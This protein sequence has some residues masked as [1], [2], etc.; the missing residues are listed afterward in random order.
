MQ[1]VYSWQCPK[2]G[3][4]YVN[5]KEPT[6]CE[7]S[8]FL[9][10]PGH[11]LADES[12]LVETRCGAPILPLEA[13]EAAREESPD[14]SDSIDACDP[15]EERISEEERAPDGPI[16]ATVVS[17]I[18]ACKWNF[19]RYAEFPAVEFSLACKRTTVRVVVTAREPE[20]QVIVSSYLALKVPPER[21][22]AAAEFIARVNYRCFTG[23]FDLD[24]ENGSVR[25]RCGIDV[26]GGTLTEKMVDTLFGMTS[27]M[28]DIY[29]DR[30]MQVIYGGEEPKAALERPEK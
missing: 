5:G 8:F 28:A 22:P 16:M 3:K 20:Q 27:Y 21:R 6:Y 17:T 10:T 15:N 11:P 19:A 25:F 13:P 9:K 29:H 14:M 1:T 30:L 24:F 12:G 4:K 2:C 26:E 23:A 18:R 7:Q